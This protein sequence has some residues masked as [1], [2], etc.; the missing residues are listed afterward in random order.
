MFTMSRF[1]LHQL[2]IIRSQVELAIA[3]A[4]MSLE[5]QPAPKDGPP[6]CEHPEEKRKASHNIG[7]E[8]EFICFACGETVKGVA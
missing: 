3:A 1:L 6:K 5:A 4:E 7:Q 2:Y 8:P